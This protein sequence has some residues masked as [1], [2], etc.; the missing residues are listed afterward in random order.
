MIVQD[1]IGFLNLKQ[2]LYYLFDRH[3][4]MPDEMW[5][6]TVEDFAATFSITRH[7]LLESLIFYLL[8]DH[9]EE[10]LQVTL[11]R[12]L[13]SLNGHFSLCQSI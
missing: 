4:T 5:R 3:W 2:L 6:Y 13:L 7:S 12:C 1:F 10:A 8:D 9:T 11:F